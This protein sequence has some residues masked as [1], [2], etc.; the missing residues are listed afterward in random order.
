MKLASIL[1]SSAAIA[2]VFIACGGTR[3]RGPNANDVS[4]TEMPT[5]PATTPMDT[6]PAVPDTNSATGGDGLVAGG[7]PAAAWTDGPGSPGGERELGGNT[8]HPVSARATGG[9]LFTDG[10]AQPNPTPRPIPQ[11]TT[12]GA[13]LPTSSG[14][15]IR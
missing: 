8:S 2:A 7:G 10:I 13:G 5:Q 4:A 3:D 6:Q 14:T 1:T 12:A 9:F 15:G 11:S